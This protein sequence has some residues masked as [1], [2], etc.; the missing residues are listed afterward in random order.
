M[1]GG[2][3]SSGVGMKET[4]ALRGRQQ[5]HPPIQQKH[6]AVS[7]QPRPE[8][9]HPEIPHNTVKPSLGK[10]RK[11]HRGPSDLLLCDQIRVVTNGKVL[12]VMLSDVNMREAILLLHSCDC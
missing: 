11:G 3:W 8:P 10:R 1:A 2:R 12:S 5:R 9:P 6:S 4:K 7:S